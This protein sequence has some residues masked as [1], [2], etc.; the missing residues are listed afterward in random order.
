MKRVLPFL[1]GI[2]PLFKGFLPLLKG[3]LLAG[4]RNPEKVYLLQDGKSHQS[5]HITVEVQARIR[6]VK[7]NAAATSHAQ[8]QK[9]GHDKSGANVH[10]CTCMCHLQYSRLKVAKKGLSM[11]IFTDLRPEWLF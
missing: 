4:M 5:R 6:C 2:L 8:Y 1:K 9:K 11:A 7:S 10:I 3:L